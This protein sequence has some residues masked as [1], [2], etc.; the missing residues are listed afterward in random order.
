MNKTII[1]GNIGKDAEVID[2][3]AGK[4]IKFPFANTEKAG[5]KEVTTWYECAIWNNKSPEKLAK[6]LV[7]G[8]KLILEG[9][10]YA[11]AYLKDGEARASMNFSVSN[12]EFIG[13]AKQETKASSEELEKDLP[14]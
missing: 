2:T 9:R 11:S 6:Y 13:G 3:K 10:S 8:M 1:T 14:F 12:F 4:L 7:K 5:E